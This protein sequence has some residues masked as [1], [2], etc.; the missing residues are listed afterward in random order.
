MAQEN[1]PVRLALISGYLGAGK[2]TLLNRM[3]SNVEGMRIAVI[4]NDIGE[5]NVDAELI[6]R[7]GAVA[8]VAEDVIPMT[9]GCICCSLSEDLEN[10]IRDLSTS[11]DY[12]YIVIEA[13][14]VCEP[15]P[16]AYT[17]AGLCE[18]DENGNSSL[19]I[20]NIISVVDCARMFDEFNGG[21]DLVEDDMDEADLAFLIVSQIEFCTTLVLN[22][23]DTVTPEQMKELRAIV[24]SLQKN[25][26]VIEAVRGDIPLDQLLNTGLYDFDTAFD[27]ATWVD[28]MDH[29]EKYD[30]RAAGH[31]HNHHDH[32]HHDH[33]H[34]HE[35]ED[36]SHCDHEH[37]VCCCGHDHAEGHDHVAEFGITTFVYERRRPLS[38]EN[39]RKLVNDWPDSVIRCKGMMWLTDDPDNCYV[40]EQ[41]GKQFFVDPNGHW[42]AS[43]D[44]EERKWIEES[45]MHALDDWDDEIGDRRIKLVFIGRDMDRDAIEAQVDALLL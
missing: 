17:L 19:V 8:E 25:A 36:H 45:N 37:G 12:D 38:M 40:F 4:V 26:K 30:E 39:L 43:A 35:H 11:G 21:Q 31:D 18:P 2:T 6:A 29:P 20:D 3:L 44:A 10:Q 33:D 5:V 42:I 15:M 41:A 14:G 22:K 7:T 1:K 27:S 13:S 16:I 32:E 28:A 34:D 9:N 24:C 23:A